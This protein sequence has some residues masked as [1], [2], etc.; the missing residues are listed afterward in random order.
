MKITKKEKKLFLIYGETGEREDV[1]QWEVGAVDDLETAKKAC[2]F[3][4]EKL[5]ALGLSYSNCAHWDSKNKLKVISQY[6]KKFICSY[7]GS[8]YHVK[9]IPTIDVEF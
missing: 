4:N 5:K 1:Y 8:S 3:L 7:T 2:E 6:D 9:E